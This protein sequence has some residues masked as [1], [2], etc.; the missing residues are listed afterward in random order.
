M[1]STPDTPRARGDHDAPHISPVTPSEDI[2]T[3]V[4][5]EVSWGAVFA[6]AVVGLI[7]QLILNMI[8]LGI[9][10]ASVNPIG[11][12]NPSAGGA[13][14][15]AGIWWIVSGL[16]AAF[17][18]G[19]LAGRLS[20]KPKESTAG[21]HGVISWAVTTIAVIYLLSSAV[22]G[23]LGGAVGAVGGA[24]GG[25][26]KTAGSAAQ[27]AAPAVANS[28]DPLGGIERQ[29]RA[30]SGGDPAAARD[31]AVSAMRAVV[32]GDPA[33]AAQ[34]R[35]EAAE[36]IARADNVP[37]PEAQA[38]VARYEAKYRAQ[39]A[40]LKERGTRAAATATN[41][42][43]TGSLVGALA[44]LLGAGAAWLGGRRGAVEP[45]VTGRF[46]P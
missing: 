40:D 32:T 12:D 31:A 5:N 26:A 20:G 24:L 18:G 17:V 36:A 1:A 15:A 2:R 33:K 41:A 19:M 6:G 22:G 27:M 42:V 28:D 30:A 35:Q 21:W 14:I 44:L 3:V 29:V 16:L 9:G 10:L 37:L 25:V 38:R 23:I 45:T 7:A 43:S 4:I 34:A 39:I 13:G 46:R 11:S 8:G